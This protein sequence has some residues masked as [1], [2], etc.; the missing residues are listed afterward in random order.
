LIKSLLIGLIFGVAGAGAL[1]WYVPAVDLHRETSLISVQ[2]N[3]GNVEVFRINLPRDRVLV[4]LPGQESSIPADL[5]WPGDEYLGN[6]QAEIFKVRDRNNAVIGLGS[7]L[8]SASEETGPFI[9]WALHFPARGT[10]YVKMEVTPSAD[11]FRNGVLR[12]GTRDFAE[13]HGS[14]REQF[15]AEANEEYDI[16][17]RIEL[18]AALVGLLEEEE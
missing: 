4:G 10:M 2:T 15:I 12:S 1:T 6:M 17:G 5:E 3:G 8:A 9:E 13:L 11:G 18:E 7:R 14:V 16:Q